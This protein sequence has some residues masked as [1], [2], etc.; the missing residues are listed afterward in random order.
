MKPSKAL[1]IKKHEVELRVYMGKIIMNKKQGILND[2][3]L[4]EYNFISS[5]RK[6]EAKFIRL[7]ILLFKIKLLIDVMA[8]LTP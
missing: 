8:G 4:K 7:S 6:S 1:T 3:I 2:K 5:N